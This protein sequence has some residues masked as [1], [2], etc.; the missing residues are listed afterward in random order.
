MG[1]KDLLGLNRVKTVSPKVEVDAG[2]AQRYKALL[3]NLLAAV[4]VRD[5]HRNII[6]C[7]PYTEVL[8]GHT[9]GELLNKGR[10]TFIDI[11]HPD[12]RDLYN[13]GMRVCEAGDPFQFRFRIMH[14][15]GIE[16]WA[17]TRA[18]PL[19]NEMDE[20]VST[21]SITFDVTGSVRYQRQ[22][23]ERNRD[24]QD[25]TY[26]LSHDLRGPVVTIQGM[27]GIINQEFEEQI[28]NE[29]RE[30]LGHIQN[31]C[32]RLD[33]LVNGVLEYSKLTLQNFESGIVDLQ[34]L[35]TRIMSEISPELERIG[36]EIEI[37][38]C[39]VSLQGDDLRLFQIFHN[40]VSNAIKY[41]DS[42]R[43]LKIEV[44]T[45]HHQNPRLI[46]VNIKD[47]GSGIPENRHQDIFQPFHRAHSPEIPGAGIGLATVKKL[48]EKLGGQI[49]V[50]SKVGVGSCFIL[51]LRSSD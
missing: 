9:L 21:L 11:V 39:A 23:E 28:N 41:R 30:V 47:N 36:G 31:A 26:M 10:D 46:K 17:E 24:I 35:L 16:V 48:V 2:A 43:P 37:Q 7:S 51:E 38:D 25:F 40:L 3:E 44:S 13:R 33:Q 34:D 5:P 45:A 12:D 15:T 22:I 1:W 42:S 32:E 4:I 27:L 6:S 20:L 19:F 14:A 29:M 18:M 8:T 50:E 49:S